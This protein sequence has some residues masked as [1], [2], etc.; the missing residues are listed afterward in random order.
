M[1][2]VVVI[3]IMGTLL[4][5]VAINFNAWQRKAFIERY[6]SELCTDLNGLRQRAMTRKMTHDA[7][8]NGSRYVFR[9]FTSAA[10]NGNAASSRIFDK[11]VGVA[12]FDKSGASLNLLI[13]FDSLGYTNSNTTIVVGSVD[14]P[15]SIN[16]L[17][18][19]TARINIGKMDG[20]DCVFR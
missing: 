5:I 8:L 1:E 11:T 17:S 15:A 12:L 16:C 18:V 20:G 3:A 7:T 10:D 9:Q 4:S 14:S 13:T 2:L 6:T 19:H